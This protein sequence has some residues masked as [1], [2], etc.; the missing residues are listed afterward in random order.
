[1]V[2]VLIKVKNKLYEEREIQD[3]MKNFYLRNRNLIISHIVLLES[4]L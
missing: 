2:K 3:I 1:M 4:I